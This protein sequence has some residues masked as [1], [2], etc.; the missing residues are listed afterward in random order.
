[1]QLGAVRVKPRFCTLD[2]RA[3]L[4]DQPPE[5]MRVVHL[6]QMGDLMGCQIIKHIGRREDQ[7]PGIGK[8]AGGGA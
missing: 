2:I 6:D 1:M 7:A 5:A 8:D 4:V 3:E